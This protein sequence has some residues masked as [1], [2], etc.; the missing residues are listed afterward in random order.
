MAERANDT[1]AAKLTHYRLSAAIY[2]A[3]FFPIMER[4][5]QVAQLVEHRTENPGVGGSIPPLSNEN[6]PRRLG[7]FFTKNAVVKLGGH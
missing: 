7:A 2:S 4:T 1:L 3:A 5:G 6:A